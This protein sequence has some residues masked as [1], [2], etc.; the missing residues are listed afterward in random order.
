MVSIAGPFVPA[1]SAV[2]PLTFLLNDLFS[3]LRF[4]VLCLDES[5]EIYW[6]RDV[7]VVGCAAAAALHPSRDGNICCSRPRMNNLPL[8]QLCFTIVFRSYSISCMVGAT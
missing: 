5:N 8:T 7:I 2:L 4:R 3:L 6:V 1:T